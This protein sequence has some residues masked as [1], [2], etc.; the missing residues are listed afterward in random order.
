MKDR[1]GKKHRLSFPSFK[2][3]CFFWFITQSVKSCRV[4]GTVMSHGFHSPFPP[5]LTICL[6]LHLQFLILTF[7]SDIPFNPKLS[8]KIKHKLANQFKENF[9]ETLKELI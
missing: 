9:P 2:E 3:V 8:H 4:G 1:K 7:R 5:K 6:H